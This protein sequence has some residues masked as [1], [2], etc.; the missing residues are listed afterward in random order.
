MIRSALKRRVRPKMGVRQSDRIRCEAFKRYVR[1]CY[2]IIFGRNGHVC[3]G[4]VQFAHVRKGND[5]GM[6]LKPSDCHGV[7]MCYA[8]HIQIQH[9]HGEP[10]FERSF[11]LDLNETA[12]AYW[13]EWLNKTPAGKRYRAEK[14]GEKR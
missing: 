10:A 3:S 2:C 6:G 8:A 13:N 5:G 14:D 9:Q 12:A 11:G 7:P 4:A 1:G